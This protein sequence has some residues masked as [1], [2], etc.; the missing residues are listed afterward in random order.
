M[1][2]HLNQM[3][4]D[5][6]NRFGKFLII[7]GLLLWVAFFATDHSRN[8]EFGLFLWGAIC[9]G[10]GGFMIWRNRP[11]APQSADRFHTVRR[12]SKGFTSWRA[13]RKEKT[14]QKKKT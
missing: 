6:P 10:V 2:N 1:E 9:L 11:P 3:K 4:E 7:I 12:A 8:P 14:I 5:T 13:R